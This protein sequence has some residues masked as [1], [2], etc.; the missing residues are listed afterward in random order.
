MDWAEIEA[1]TAANNQRE[2]LFGVVGGTY[3]VV[4]AILLLAVVGAIAYVAKSAQPDVD[5]ATARAMQEIRYSV[6]TVMPTL[7]DLLDACQL[8]D[9]PKTGRDFFLCTEASSDDCQTEDSMTQHYGLPVY[10]CE[11]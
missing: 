2:D 11:I 8:V 4:D 5:L 10:L 6:G 7:D 3:L 1:L 9:D